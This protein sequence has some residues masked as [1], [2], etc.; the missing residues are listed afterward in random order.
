MDEILKNRKLEVLAVGES[1][2]NKNLKDM[3]KDLGKKKRI[4]ND[5]EGDVN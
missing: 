2:V 4:V 3:L 5:F 1:N